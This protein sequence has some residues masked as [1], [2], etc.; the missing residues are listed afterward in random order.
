[1]SIFTTIEGF[2]SKADTAIT[3]GLTDVKAG[4][5]TVDNFVGVVL[6]QAQIVGGIVVLVD[7]PLGVEIEAGVTALTALRATV[8][9]AV[10]TGSSDLTTLAKD[11]LT[12]GNEALTLAAQV[13]PFY[14][15]AA[16]EASAVDTA[17][18]AAVKALP[19]IPATV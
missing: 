17:A 6:G 13:A 10:A 11:V 7:P 1:M 19:T 12:L 15:V 4:A 2:F 3:T 8:K 5:T 9:A 14:S 16:K 18:V